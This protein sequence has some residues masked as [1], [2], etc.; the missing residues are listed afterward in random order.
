[1]SN[2]KS[3]R[4]LIIDDLVQDYYDDSDFY[5][6]KW[7]KSTGL[8]KENY[9]RFLAPLT[10]QDLLDKYRSRIEDRRS[11]QYDTPLED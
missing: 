10:D 8:P 3:L 11:S 2:T 9:S 1:M 4:D 6:S 5:E 7:A